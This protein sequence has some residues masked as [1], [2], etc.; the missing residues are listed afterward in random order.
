M[1]EILGFEASE[2]LGIAAGVL[3]AASMVPQVVKMIQEKKASQ[4]SILMILVLIGGICL[5]IWYGLLKD[6]KPIV[7]TNAFSLMVNIFLVVL[8]IRYRNNKED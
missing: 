4:V 6:D 2:V 1:A 7:Y 8:R 3:T 5:W